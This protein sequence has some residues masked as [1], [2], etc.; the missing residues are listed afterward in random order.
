M[1]G[2]VKEAVCSGCHDR[3]L[4]VSRYLEGERITAKSLHSI[5]LKS[6]IM[7]VIEQAGF[8]DVGI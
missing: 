8:G 2:C 6:L 3:E 5:L 4:D 7:F 1:G